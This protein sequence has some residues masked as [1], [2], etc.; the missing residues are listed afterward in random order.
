MHENE[1]SMLS[2]LTSCILISKINSALSLDHTKRQWVDLGTHT[3]ICMIRLETC[4]AA[5]GAI[6]LWVRLNHCPD[7]SGILT[8]HGSGTGFE[9]YCRDNRMRYSSY[10]NISLAVH[11]FLFKSIFS[12]YLK[13]IYKIS[14]MNLSV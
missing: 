5:G 6:S 11:T 2:T 9:I 13:C 10:L 3:E 4:G 8:T 7:W 14:C 1:F 12:N